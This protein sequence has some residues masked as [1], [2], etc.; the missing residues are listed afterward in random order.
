M[1]SGGSSSFGAGP[2]WRKKI[3]VSF[4]WSSHVPSR[5][6]PATGGFQMG[7]PPVFGKIQFPSRVWNFYSHPIKASFKQIL[8]SPNTWEP[9]GMNFWISPPL[10]HHRH[11]ENR[12][13]IHWSSAAPYLSKAT[14]SCGMN[15][16]W[17][18]PRGGAN[19]AEAG[20]WVFSHSSHLEY[21][22]GRRKVKEEGIVLRIK[23]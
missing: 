22:W 16:C 7:E 8:S 11:P 20:V 17:P 6:R 18:K 1:S 3:G 19:S 10:F 4:S 15:L 2:G 9:A 23:H 14:H 5:Q 13:A 21:I 12:A